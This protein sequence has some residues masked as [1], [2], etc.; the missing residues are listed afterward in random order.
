M[1]LWPFKKKKPTPPFT[2]NRNFYLSVL[3]GPGA[4]PPILQLVNPQGSNAAVQGFCAPLSPEASKDLLNQ[5]LMPGTYV[6]TTTDKLTI[7]Q[8]DVFRR[9]DVA[10]FQLPNDPLQLEAAHLT[11]RRLAR[12][13]KCEWLINFIFK[14]Y[15]PDAYSSV[16]FML[17]VCARLATLTEGVIADPLAEVYR[18][19][20]EVSLVPKLDPRIDF[21]EVGSIRAIR[22][23]GGVWISTRGMLKF[24]L[25]EYEMF[26]L[27][28]DLVDAAARMLISAA[29]QTLIGMPLRLGDTAFATSSPLRVVEGTRGDWDGRTVYELRD[30]NGDGAANGV[31]AW[32]EQGN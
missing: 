5:P 28:D 14:G 4:L 17:D 18:L 29:Q 24:D 27:N 8:M 32:M 23:N 16:R 6:A 22:I 31:R 10:N 25:P 26:G 1:P 12:A 30:V 2:I 9:S 19:P 3:A 13:E 20:E 15:S 11:G 7:L 21:R